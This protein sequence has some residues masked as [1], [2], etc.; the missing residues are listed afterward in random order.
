MLSLLVMAATVVPLTA[1]TTES[2]T[3]Q[4]VSLI[5]T[6]AT[7]I[8]PAV[9]STTEVTDRGGLG[10]CTWRTGAF[11]SCSACIDGTRTREVYC[12]CILASN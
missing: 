12:Q 3:G 6:A 9:F 7:E 4:L 5:T 1:Q 11:G 10:T 8:F 2:P